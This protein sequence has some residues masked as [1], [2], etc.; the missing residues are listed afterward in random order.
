MLLVSGIANTHK[1]TFILASCFCLVLPPRPG[2]AGCTS[3]VALYPL[4]VVRS[5]ITV[6][7]AA[8]AAAA[9]AGATASATSVAAVRAGGLA[10]AGG[11]GL[12][13]SLQTIVRREGAGAL[14]K[15]LG[16]S[17]AAIF[18]EAAITYGL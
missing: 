17:V 11:L 15:G 10:G 16:P 5:R 3:W 13:E 1:Q 14:Y 12:V 18:P 6:A 2:L 7:G 4:E 8:A 9:S